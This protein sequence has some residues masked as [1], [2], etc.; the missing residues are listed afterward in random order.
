MDAIS[1]GT[2][3]AQA[4]TSAAPKGPDR[5]ITSEP[6]VSQ[7]MDSADS[8]NWEMA[9]WDNGRPFNCT[10][11]PDNISFNDGLMTL[12]LDEEGC[13]GSCES[14]PYASGEYR[15]RQETFHYGDYEV[16][17]KPAA[18]D[19]LNSSFFVY[20]GQPGER[21]HHEIDIEFLGKDCESF[22]A[23]YFVEGRGG[24]EEI[25]RLPFNACLEWHNYGFRW[26]ENYI[27]WYVDGEVVHTETTADDTIPYEPGKIMVNLWPGIGV[28][29]WL[30]YFEYPGHPLSTQYDWIEYAPLSQE[31]EDMI[32]VA[33]EK[34]GPG[35]V[36]QQDAATF[37][38][39]WY[40]EN[41]TYITDTR[42][43]KAAI[44]RAQKTKEQLE[45]KISVNR[46]E[47]ILYKRALT[48]LYQSKSELGETIILIWL[49]SRNIGEPKSPA[50]L[51]EAL[52][53]LQ[54]GS[55]EHAVDDWAEWRITYWPA[56]LALILSSELEDPQLREPLQSI[57]PGL[58][59]DTSLDI[60]EQE[61]QA[62]EHIYTTL[63]EGNRRLSVFQGESL[64]RRALLHKSLGDPS[65]CDGLLSSAKEALQHVATTEQ[66]SNGFPKISAKQKKHIPQL[67]TE[68]EEELLKHVAWANVLYANVLMFEAEEE[69]DFG[70]KLKLLE[71][72]Q[73]YLENTAPL[74]DLDALEARRVL[75]ENLTQQAYANKNLGRTF[76]PQLAQALEHLHYIVGWQQEYLSNPT[77]AG[78]EPRWLA[79][80]TSAS[81]IA[82]AKIL[83]VAA[84]EINY[85]TEPQAIALFTPYLDTA[86]IQTL[87]GNP[88]KEAALHIQLKLLKQAEETLYNEI[89][90]VKHQ[91]LSDLQLVLA[92]NYARQAF[93]AKDLGNLASYTQKSENAKRE[94]DL[95]LQAQVTA[96]PKDRPSPQT[97][98][99]ANLWMAKILFVSAG[100]AENYQVGQS[101]LDGAMEYANAAIDSGEITGSLLSSAYQSRGE[102]LLGK[103][104]LEGTGHFAADFAN[105]L[106]AAESELETALPIYPQNYEAK[107]S[108]GDALNQQGR[109]SEAITYYQEVLDLYPNHFITRRAELGIAE[110]RMREQENYSTEH[111]EELEEVAFDIL[112]NESRGS[113]LVPRAIDALIEAYSTSEENHEK[114]VLLANEWTSN[115][116]FNP[117]F[118]AKLYIRLAEA[119][120]WLDRKKTAEAQRILREIPRDL[121]QVIEKDSELNPYYQL[122]SAELRMRRQRLAAPIVDNSLQTIIDES[123]N[124]QLQARLVLD[125]IEGH[126]YPR[127]FKE[128]VKI[129]RDHLDPTRLSEIEALYAS[130]GIPNGFVKYKFA[131]W[132]KL[133]EALTWDN[134]NKP[135]DKAL[136]EIELLRAALP[137]LEAALPDQ[138]R[139]L[140]A[141]L[142]LI[143]GDLYTYQWEDQ[144]FA[145]AYQAY[146]EAENV[147][148]T[149]S[150][151]NNSSKILYA[152]VLMAQGQLFLYAHSGN[153]KITRAL[154]NELGF[155]RKLFYGTA[156]ER[157]MLARDILLDLPEASKTK[158][159]LLARLYLNWA[160]LE[161]A[162][163]DFTQA[164]KYISEA[165]DNYQKYAPNQ[166]ASDITS[167]YNNLAAMT[168]PQFYTT[169]QFFNGSGG[170]NEG[171]I[172]TTFE[173][174]F[175]FAK[176][177]NWF[178]PIVSEQIDIGGAGRRA[179][180]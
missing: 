29:R 68:D 30:G 119:T 28:D 81:R 157:F 21:S 75:A 140:D 154:K 23:N 156:D 54:A 90:I 59:L 9:N 155:D 36:G 129:A 104:S 39:Y 102:I 12:T 7:E 94:L 86:D 1:L 20:S 148:G 2:Y 31:D 178:H 170:Q 111:I 41:R 19:G 103:K 139:L 4:V 130:R 5:L 162:N 124:P 95:I 3:L 99:M 10:W 71:A 15:T 17:M 106:A 67:V 159:A 153:G 53:L 108:L 57:L 112:A 141:E 123:G 24:H 79:N 93:I 166:I 35:L 144:D 150:N 69:D 131:L 133:V 8:R 85:Q 117:R 136:E 45:E 76:L 42:T 180:T 135:Y 96:E 49:S 151:P 80:I 58:N 138:A 84:G 175:S 22:Q 161:Q 110:C 179:T 70:E 147:L 16:R 152:K 40:S 97:S 60:R 160:L 83:M 126:S 14:W 177:F 101:A 13:P 165:V 176:G 87:E 72:A 48:Q 105:P 109:Y 32:I 107:L 118:R 11:Q 82:H 146:Q 6:T 122:V 74:K 120:S 168:R 89:G 116:V 55:G 149:I 127:K 137:E 66:R 46:Y 172:T 63:L 34:S 163:K 158:K 52:P 25:V 114:I 65:A 125:Q 47:R 91:A 37:V 64:Y 78:T 33:P 113:F 56:Q 121:E 62:L 88:S 92:E 169:F 142:Y 145:K 38:G 43:L 143:Q 171:Q 132:K 167:T 77:F 134:I 50:S 44:G 174:P 26:A 61:K 115:D 98:A 173:L 27:E 51:L 18:G 128:V 100:N 73:A 164:F